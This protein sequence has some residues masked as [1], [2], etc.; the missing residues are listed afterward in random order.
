MK[1]KDLHIDSIESW[2]KNK[3]CNGG[4]DIFWSA[5]IGFGCLRLVIE[6]DGQLTVYSELMC[7]NNDK[8]FIDMIF[9]E[10]IKQI[11]VIE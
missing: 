4:I 8:K 7:D 10:I 5:N 1:I 2:G 9:K 6:K 11:N 3:I